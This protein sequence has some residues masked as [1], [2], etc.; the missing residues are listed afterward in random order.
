MWGKEWF[1]QPEGAIWGL[2]GRERLKQDRAE[3]HTH[4]SFHSC[5]FIW[6]HCA[7]QEMPST[8]SMKTSSSMVKAKQTINKTREQNAQ[9]DDYS[10]Y[11]LWHSSLQ[12]SWSFIKDLTFCN[13]WSLMAKAHFALALP[14]SVIPVFGTANTRLCLDNSDFCDIVLPWNNLYSW[15]RSCGPHTPAQPGVWY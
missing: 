14:L 8:V 13:S 2:E 5:V 6:A 1:G 9:L 10:R 3:P 11:L 12:L 15:F 4:T 7:S